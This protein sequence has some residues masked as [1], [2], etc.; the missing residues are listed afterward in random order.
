M[1]E[2]AVKPISNVFKKYKSVIY[3]NPYILTPPVVQA[4]E[5]TFIGGVADTLYTPELLA[6]KLAINVSRIS[7]FSVLGNDIKCKITGQYEIP[8]VCFSGNVSITSF[9]DSD[10]LVTD[11]KGGA[12]RDCPKLKGSLYFGGVV[13]LTGTGGEVFSNSG[14][15]DVIMPNLTSITTN[16]AIFA[17]SSNLRTFYA[18]NLTT[19]GTSKGSNAVFTNYGRTQHSLKVYVNPSMQTSNSGALEGD[20]QQLIDLKGSV[21]FVS[22]FIKPNAVTTLS[23]GTVLK[24]AVQLNFSG[25]TSSNL[26]DYYDCYANG[27]LM[28]R[29]KSSGEYITGLSA[30]TSYVITIVAVD[31]LYNKSLVSNS[32]SVTT[33]NVSV[34]NNLGLISYYKLDSNSIDSVNSNN[35]VDTSVTYSAGKLGNTAVF[36]GT[37]SKIIV[38]NPNNLKLSQGTISVWV[39]TLNPGI[40][41]RSIFGKTLAY[42]VFMENSI[43]GVYSWAGSAG[44]RSTN[45]NISDGIWHHLAFVFESGTNLNYLYLDGVLVLTTT[46]TITDQ[47]DNVCIGSSNSTQYFNG[48]IDE[49]S[50][51]SQKLTAIQVNLLYNNGV[52]VTL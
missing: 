6:S 22:N 21:A 24:S 42:N 30:S 10:N 50:I 9:V 38:G 15:T 20:L 13:N 37:S 47:T 48:S 2:I 32:V 28:N 40:S 33:N 52:G 44:Y 8:V 12:F 11:I 16:V 5:N 39:K 36:N 1:G 4:P 25:P 43:L 45:I 41:F 7:H 19:I 34:L 49:A 51:H 18:P 29:I 31:V 14:I 35:G 27:K 23:T 3:V 46:V 26:I 17:L